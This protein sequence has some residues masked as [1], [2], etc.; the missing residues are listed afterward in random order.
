MQSTEEL[1]KLRMR[2]PNARQYIFEGDK[3]T[4]EFNG[5]PSQ[6][7]VLSVEF[8]ERCETGYR[9][10]TKPAL[11]RGVGIDQGWFKKIK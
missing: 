7:E 1:E 5:N 11:G 6:H 3:V 2:R 4:T 9:V 8:D 10:K